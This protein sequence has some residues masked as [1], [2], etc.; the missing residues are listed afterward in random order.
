MNWKGIVT[1][2][3]QETKIQE[4]HNRLHNLST[5]M[6]DCMEVKESKIGSLSSIEAKYVSILEIVKDLL[7]VKQV[8]EFPNQA[9]KLPIVIQVDNIGAIYTAEN[10]SSNSQ[11]KH[12]NVWYHFV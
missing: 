5:R 6:L 9:I 7:F 4:K 8:L 10:G 1:V 2:I 12:V 11:T 3:M